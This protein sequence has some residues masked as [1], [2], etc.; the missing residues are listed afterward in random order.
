MTARFF[1]FECSKRAVTDRAY[2]RKTFLLGNFLTASGIIASE[3]GT[4]EERRTT[5]ARVPAGITTSL[6]T[7]LRS[8]SQ[9]CLWFLQAPFKQCRSGRGAR[10]GDIC[11]HPSRP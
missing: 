6:R 1:A 5:Y 10:P 2:R 4:H 11:G 3:D 9:S 8:L 7:A